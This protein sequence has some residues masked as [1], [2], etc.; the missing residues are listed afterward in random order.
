[1]DSV[2]WLLIGFV[3]GLVFANR[4]KFAPAFR[5]AQNL[6]EAIVGKKK[7]PASPNEQATT[8][9]VIVDVVKEEKKGEE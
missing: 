2:W 4:E 1:M 5:E 9:T 3:A 8:K 6:A 7:K